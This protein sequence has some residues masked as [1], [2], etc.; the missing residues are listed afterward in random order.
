M[1]STHRQS[2]PQHRYLSHTHTKRSR[3]WAHTIAK[4]RA[5]HGNQ[6]FN[7]YIETR[8][9]AL[10]W[11]IVLWAAATTTSSANHYIKNTQFVHSC[12]CHLS[13][14]LCVSRSSTILYSNTNRTSVVYFITHGP[15][16]Y[17][18]NI[19][20][21]TNDGFHFIHR[22]IRQQQQKPF[23][24]KMLPYVRWLHIYMGVVC[25]CVR[26]ACECL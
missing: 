2:Q 6:W 5:S 3:L 21:R 26:C 10:R 8:A 7:V 22:S 16:S 11:Y 23:F 17:M 4:R 13:R 15:T 20:T 12:L 24:H 18:Y 14:V 19:S 1:T 9:F 25:A